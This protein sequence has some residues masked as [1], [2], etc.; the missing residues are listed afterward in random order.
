MRNISKRR[1]W[2]RRLR[3]QEIR[4]QNFSQKNYCTCFSSKQKQFLYLEAVSLFNINKIDK[5]KQQSK[6][7]NQ[8]NYQIK[9]SIIAQIIKF[10]MTKMI[11]IMFHN[12]KDQQILLSLRLSNL[13]ML[14]RPWPWRI[15]KQ[16]IYRKKLSVFSLQIELIVILVQKIDLLSQPLK[17]SSKFQEQI[18]KS[19]SVNTQVV[20]S[21]E[22]K[23]K[24]MENIKNKNLSDKLVEFIFKMRQNL[25]KEMYILFSKEWLN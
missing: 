11:Q 16:F 6:G 17:L 9:C 10:K 12:K 14:A 25:S 8:T 4:Q 24:N 2:R 20:K 18:K 19:V 5:H 23:F 15:T 21:I 13:G 3:S 1:K 7:C 22:E